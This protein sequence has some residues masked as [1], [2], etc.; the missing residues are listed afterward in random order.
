MPTIELYAK[1]KKRVFMTMIL[2]KLFR[3]TIKN[4]GQ[5]QLNLIYLY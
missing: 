1:F 3:K 4:F 5:E 2:L